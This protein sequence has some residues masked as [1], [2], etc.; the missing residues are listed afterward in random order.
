[1]E[2]LSSV[3]EPRRV[4]GNRSPGG[5]SGGNK[6]ASGVMRSQTVTATGTEGY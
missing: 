1:M 3:R 5:T 4:R 2:W 6:L